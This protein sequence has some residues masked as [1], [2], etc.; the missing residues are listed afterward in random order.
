M[1]K[2]LSIA[3][4]AVQATFAVVS[5]AALSSPAEARGHHR[6]YRQSHRHYHFS[7]DRGRHHEGR[8]HH[9][10]MREGCHRRHCGAVRAAWH[11]R[12]KDSRH[13]TSSHR[14]DLGSLARPASFGGTLAAK[15]HEIVANCGSAVI[16]SF[17]AGARVAGSG[18]A[19]LHASGRAVDV[20]GNPGCIYAHL[21]GWSGGYS[22]DY[23][24]VQHVHIS[25][26]GREDGLR[27]AHHSS[28]HAHHRYGRHRA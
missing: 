21:H 22:T 1:L 20:R 16:S 17:R 23:A 26:G 10:A 19:S 5:C 7:H 8:D 15:T 3:A 14:K 6:Q 2:T 27:F 12:R 18:R 25:L 13:L 28:H 9:V 11:V 4:L 24:A